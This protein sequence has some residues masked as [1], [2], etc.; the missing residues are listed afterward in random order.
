EGE[1]VGDP[2]VGPFLARADADEG[3][4]DAYDALID[5]A[6]GERSGEMERVLSEE[7]SHVDSYQQ[8]SLALE[9]GA[10]DVVGGIAYANFIGL[11]NKVDDLFLRS[12]VGRV[13]LVWAEREEHRTRVDSLTRARSRE[14]HA[15]DDEFRE[16]MDEKRPEDKGEEE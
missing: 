2:Q 1:G 9:D 12:D 7:R 14:L 16:I 4:L 8:T 15:L 6:V 11:R 13:D 5:S 3:R 10:A